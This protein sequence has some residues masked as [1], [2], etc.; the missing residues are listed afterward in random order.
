MNPHRSPYRR[1]EGRNQYRLKHFLW[2]C[3]GEDA[4]KVGQFE[5]RFFDAGGRLTLHPPVDPGIPEI[6]IGRLLGWEAGDVPLLEFDVEAYAERQHDLWGEATADLE[7]WPEH[8]V[9]W[10][11][12]GAIFSDKCNDRH[13]LSPADVLFHKEAACLAAMHEWAEQVL[14]VEAPHH[15]AYRSH[16]PLSIMAGV[17]E[18]IPGVR[19]GE[20]PE[21]VW[22]HD[23]IAVW[24]VDGAIHSGSQSWFRAQVTRCESLFDKE[25]RPAGSGPVTTQVGPWYPMRLDRDFRRLP[26]PAAAPDV[27]ERP[28]PWRPS[29]VPLTWGDRMEVTGG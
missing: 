14:L 25:G 15:L 26:D 1:Y 9:A 4:W 27:L 11:V 13:P 6:C 22:K 18:H 10:K 21:W 17:A 19:R 12:P 5:A 3:V 7:P 16:S 2:W 29:Q 24:C 23:H 28:Y 20:S 8:Q